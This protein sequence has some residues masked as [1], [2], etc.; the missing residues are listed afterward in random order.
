[1]TGWAFGPKGVTI[2]RAIGFNRP[3]FDFQP[4]VLMTLGKNI[5]F[6]TRLNA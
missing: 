6:Q 1:M 4:I 3:E 2:G 5:A